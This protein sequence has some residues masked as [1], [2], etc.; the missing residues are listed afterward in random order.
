MK[1]LFCT[2]AYEN[3]TNGPTKFANIL[4]NNIISRFEVRVLTED[5]TDEIP[6]KVYKTEIKINKFLKPFGQFYRMYKYHKDA[7]KIR[8]KYKFDI[9]VYNN[10]FI[11]LLSSC[12]FKNTVGMINDYSNAT[13][14]ITSVFLGKEKFNK[15]IVFHYVERFYCRRKKANIIVNSKDLKLK[16]LNYYN[17]KE[18]NIFVLNKA[19]ENELIEK[20]STIDFN[21]KNKKTILFVK[22]DYKLGGL[23]DLINGLLLMPNQNFH[24]TIVGP[25][26]NNH[27]KIID[28]INNRF[29]FKLYGQTN[30]K[31]V[32]EMMRSHEIFSVPSHKEAFGVAN[33][34]A[35]AHGCKIV[36][37]NVGG[38][39]EAV[40]NLNTTILVDPASPSKISLALQEIEK[41]K[42]TER[43]RIQISERLSK[44]SEKNVLNNFKDILLNIYETNNTRS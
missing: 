27:Q 26:K 16:L 24:L 5:I 41:Y 39:P 43:D 4:A 19:L 28:Q 22:T 17:C 12:F 30:Q 8:Q 2:N 21:E 31:E 20:N 11:G 1:I 15:R 29:S 42:I 37:T 9:L 6:N 36:S 32:F 35:I 18:N 33:L 3:I 34:E 7:I 14:N 40:G 13:V 25:T 44:F 38:I 10:A 23:F